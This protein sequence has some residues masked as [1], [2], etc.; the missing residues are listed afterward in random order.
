[1]LH[2]YGPLSPTAV[3]LHRGWA[4]SDCTQSVLC[5]LVF[6]QKFTKC[7]AHCLCMLL[8]QLCKIQEAPKLVGLCSWQQFFWGKV[9]IWPHLESRT[10]GL[11]E[12]QHLHEIPQGAEGE[13]GPLLS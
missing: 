11:L 9:S 10:L 4:N 13:M 1:M 3:K 8:L 5:T 7:T 2:L 12:G 6:T